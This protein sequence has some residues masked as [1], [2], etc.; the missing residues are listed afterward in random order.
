MIKKEVKVMTILFLLFILL[1]IILK[2]SF[3][4]AKNDNYKDKI[5]SEVYEKLKHNN[6]TRVVIEF[7]NLNMSYNK[8]EI[9]KKIDIKKIK[10]ILK[11]SLSVEIESSDLD[12]L[13]NLEII[14]EIKEDRII[15]YFLQDSIP[16]INASS[17]WNIRVNELNL[18]GIDE[19]ICILDTGINFS[20][21]DLKGKNKTCN[22]DCVYEN[23]IE[24]CSMNDDN[25]HGTHVA[26]IAAAYGN[27]SGVAIQSEIIGVKVLNSNGI[28]YGS[29]LNAGIEW[30][31]DHSSEYNISV[32]SMSL[33]DC[34]NHS[35]YCNDDESA[36]Y[37]NEA[38]AKNISVIVAA[39]NGPGGS[40]T[41]ITNTQGPSAPACV[42]NATAVGA[43]DDYDN[44][45]Y[46]RGTLFELLA[47][48]I[49][50]NSTK[51]N[52]LYE[53][54]SGTSMAAP[55]VAGAVAIL[56][57]F[58]RL[59]NNKNLTPSLIKLVLNSSGKKINDSSGTGLIFSRINILDSIIS[60]DSVAPNVNLISPENNSIN[61]SKN[62]VFS[63]NATDSIGLSQISLYIWDLNGNL[64]YNN[65]SNISGNNNF[66]QFTNA[67]LING[68][69]LWNCKA[70]DLNGNQ[71]FSLNNF[72]I[73][74]SLP[75]WG[76]INSIFTTLSNGSETTSERV[77]N[78]KTY[79]DF[80]STIEHDRQISNEEWNINRNE[81]NSNNTD[82]NFTYFLGYKW[83]GASSGN[84]EIS[85][86]F[87]D[88]GTTYHVRGDD[89]NN[90][91][92][93]ELSKWLYENNG[94]GCIS[95]PAKIGNSVNWSEDGINNETIFPCVEILNKHYYHWNDY[96]NCSNNSGCNTYENPS[97]GFSNWNGSVK[98]AL[99][100][101]LHLGFVGGWEHYESLA[102][103]NVYIGIVNV[104]N[105]TRSGVIDAIKKRHTWASQDKI[106]M[107]VNSSNGSNSFV[108]GDKF[109]HPYN[110][111]YISFDITASEGKLIKNI[112][113][114]Y[115]GI[116]IN[117]TQHSS[118]NVQGTFFINFSDNKEHYIFIEAVQNDSSRAW[119]SPMYVTSGLN[120][121]VYIK[122]LNNYSI[123][124][125]SVIINWT[126]DEP[127][128][129]SINYGTTINLGTI[130][131]NSTLST[132]HSFILNN[133]NSNTNYYYN[134]T[135]CNSYSNC[136]TD[137]IYS[138]ITSSTDSTDVREY[139]ISGASSEGGSGGI[140]EKS[141][142]SNVYVLTDKDLM[143]GFTKKLS[144]GD[145]I[146]FKLNDEIYYNLIVNEINETF[147]K[148]TI[149]NKIKNL[150]LLIGEEYK[151]N[152]SSS[153]NYDLFLRLNSIEKQK[154]NLTLRSINE[155]VNKIQDNIINESDNNENED[156]NFVERSSKDKMSNNQMIYIFSIGFIS[157]LIILLMIIIIFF[158]IQIRDKKDNLKEQKIN[159]YKNIF[160]KHIKPNE[161]NLRYL[162]Y[163]KK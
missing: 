57:Q 160:K 46:Q 109:Y 148:I 103:P 152:I 123:N 151:L 38:V 65:I 66:T 107:K 156:N 140:S 79:Y 69:Y 99:D 138:F 17:V 4:C 60:L 64:V 142:T 25:G 130:V 56:K 128:N 110:N 161:K 41:G 153:E 159:E 104:E 111:L 16:L 150:K 32:I 28:G 54:R 115:D 147:I 129:A 14:K 34:S 120:N 100:K 42:E 26:G 40:C 43:V 126:T 78:L 35:T 112:S 53:I 20:H 134:V 90:D 12:K 105:W 141:N 92:F 135:S 47:P 131:G 2:L 13:K 89:I 84:S 76:I 29:D 144:K 133:L 155:Y 68:K 85:I 63:C 18:T 55:H 124:S 94:I 30:C 98:N 59:Q 96:W 39:G 44:I 139:S 114:F 5:K 81:A 127:T 36:P 48:G 24:N 102:I 8:N 73:N 132:I 116:I 15:S 121:F 158:I 143:L 163:R 3:I 157:I 86:F 125:T 21:P 7:N 75:I 101:G 45:F 83:K 82:N 119:S 1:F 91:T 106:I 62:P 6:K 23:C 67:N 50:I 117:F 52:G 51:K 22:I 10:R 113:L 118:S 145:I 146:K 154:A 108:M 70:T 80:A 122:N 74:I 49:S 87:A 137:G 136:S 27:I 93:L 149:K 61:Y 58:Y 33:G 88:N 95:N 9:E 11:N 162:K 72:S 97:P 37:I 71:A 19:T 77:I 31:I